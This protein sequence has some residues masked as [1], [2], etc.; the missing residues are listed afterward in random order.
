MCSLHAWNLKTCATTNTQNPAYDYWRHFDVFTMRGWG[1]NRSNVYVGSSGTVT[2]WS[3]HILSWVW[4]VEAADLSSGISTSGLRRV[5]P[6]HSLSACMCKHKDGCTRVVPGSSHL[7]D[8][9]L[10]FGGRM[11]IYDVLVS[12][13]RQDSVCCGMWWYGH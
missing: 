9:F 11:L 7:R 1:S 12:S 8:T 2:Y 5:L 10:T 3:W 6:F 13:H 4:L